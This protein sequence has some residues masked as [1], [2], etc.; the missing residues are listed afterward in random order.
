VCRLCGRPLR[1]ITYKA[2]GVERRALGQCVCQIVAQKQREKEL[3]DRG[4]RQ[5]LQQLFGDEWLPPHVEEMTLAA[6]EAR[7]GTERAVVEVRAYIDR[8]PKQMKDGAGL[9]LIGANCGNGKSHLAGAIAGGVF[10]AG[11]FPIWANLTRL[12]VRLDGARGPRGKEREADILT[13]L[14]DCDLLVL[15]D[16]GVEAWR[17]WRQDRLYLV[18][19]ARTEA[20][21]PIV[22]TT[23]AQ[24]LDELRQHV[25]NRVLDRL[26]AACVMVE[27]TATSYRLEIAKRR[28]AKG[29]AA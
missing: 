21:K 25:G 5:R 18:V 20:R 29:G 1:Y 15:D 3:A 24:D 12:M 2:L 27:N 7:P 9:M 13:A 28:L 23:N 6:F 22:A 26:V 19:N 10:E 16:L 14:M 11:G 17:D 8:W 4:R